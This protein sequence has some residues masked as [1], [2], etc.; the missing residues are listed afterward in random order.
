MYRNPIKVVGTITCLVGIILMVASGL[1]P[2]VHLGQTH[3]GVSLGCHTVTVS[4][5][6]HNGLPQVDTYCKVS[7]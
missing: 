7:L 4:F 6:L 3:A 1:R 5:L 2:S